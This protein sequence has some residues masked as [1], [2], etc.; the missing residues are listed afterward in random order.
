M[1]TPI[2]LNEAIIALK[3]T[4]GQR[5]TAVKLVGQLRNALYCLL[6]RPRAKESRQMAEQAFS[7]SSDWYLNYKAIEQRPT[8]EADEAEAAAERARGYM[9]D[10]AL[11]Q[12]PE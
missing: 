8:C 11:E 2:D 1:T 5:D 7:A 6:E 3:F 10:A 4:R 9:E 12:S